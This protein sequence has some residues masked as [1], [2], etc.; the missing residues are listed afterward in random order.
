QKLMS[1]VYRTGQRFGTGH[2]IDVLTGKTTE[3][4]TRFGHDA[5]SV[6]GIGETIALKTWQSIARQLVAAG[7]IDVDHAQF[8]ALILTEKSRTILRGEETI[9]LRKDRNAAGLKKTR[10]S[11]SASLADDLDQDDR[12]LFERLRRL[13]TQIARDQGVP[14]YVVFPDATLAGM[15]S[16]RPVTSDGLLDVSGVGQSKL[17][18]Y[19]EAFLDLVEAFEAGV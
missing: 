2:V 5:L 15:A 7:Y 13:R 6:F 4:T 9:A 8:G 10:T 12:L 1:A 14:P 17:E 3:K 16:A 11:R 18:K 19:G